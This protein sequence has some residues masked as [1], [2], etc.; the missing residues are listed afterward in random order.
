[1]KKKLCPKFGDRINEM[2]KMWKYCPVSK[3]GQKL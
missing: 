2:E 3:E 1:M